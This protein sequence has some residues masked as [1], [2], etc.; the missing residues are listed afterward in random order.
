MM[1]KFK[2]II[3]ALLLFISYSGFAQPGIP[4]LPGGD[5]DVVDNAP[6]DQ[7]GFIVFALLAGIGLGVY[8]LRKKRLQSVK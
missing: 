4:G 5:S 3:L 2:K 7:T 1:E 6:I 8:I